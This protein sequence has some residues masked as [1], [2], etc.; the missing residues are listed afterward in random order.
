VGFW[1]GERSGKLDATTERILS[2]G[3]TLSVAVLS[4]LGGL[5]LVV[6]SLSDTNVKLS[7]ELTRVEDP[8]ARRVGPS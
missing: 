2:K 1:N 8:Q 5:A 3:A 6:K 7:L 4:L